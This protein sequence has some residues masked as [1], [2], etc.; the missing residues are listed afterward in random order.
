VNVVRRL[1]HDLAYQME[2]ERSSTLLSTRVPP[3]D[4]PEIGGTT[5]ETACLTLE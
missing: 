3:T 5:E 4:D 2:E 1:L